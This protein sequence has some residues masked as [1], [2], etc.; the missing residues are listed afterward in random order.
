MS[1]NNHSESYLEL[2]GK[3][4]AF[5]RKYYKNL[6]IKG[7]LYSVGLILIFFLVVAVLEYVGN[8][9]PAVRGVMFYGLLLGSSVL[10]I[11]YIVIPALRLFRLGKVISHAEAAAIVGRHFGS[12]N[13]KVLNTLQLESLRSSSHSDLL[14]ASIDQKIAEL[15]PVPFTDAINFGENKKYLRFVIPP[16]LVLLVLLV[17]APNIITESTTRIVKHTESFE[18]VAPFSFHIEN[19]RLESPTQADYLLRLSMSGEQVP[20]RVYIVANGQRMKMK[21]DGT[22]LHSHKFNAVQEDIPFWFEASGFRSEDFV[23]RALPSPVLLHFDVTAS[24]PPH[25]RLPDETFKNTGNLTVPEGTALRWKFSTKDAD[26]LKLWINNEWFSPDR[27]AS[28]RFDYS[29]VAMHNQPYAVKVTNQFVKETD[30]LSYRLQVISDR[31]PSIDAEERADS[32]NTRLK[33]FNGLIKDDYGFTRLTFNYRFVTTNDSSRSREVVRTNLGIAGDQTQQQFFHYWNMG[34]LSLKAG[35]AVEYYFEVWDNDG[36]H[37]AKSSRSATRTYKAPSEDELLAERDQS[38]QKIKDDLEKAIKEARSL[39]K[40]AEDLNRELLEKK[41]LTWQDKKKLEDLVARQQQMQQ[42]IDQ[43]KQEN[44]RSNQRQE[45]FQQQNN[46][47]LEKQQQLEKLFEQVM[48][49]EMRKMYERLEELMNELDKDK[50]QQELEELKW[51]NK[52]VEKELDRALEQFKQLEFEMKM[53]ETLEKLEKLAEEQDK[54]AEESKDK[55]SDS[56]ELKEKQDKLNEEFEKLREDLD[57]LKEKNEE[58][59]TPMDMEDTD[60]MEE[61][62]GEDMKDSSDQLEQNQKSKASEKQEGASQKMKQMANQMA[63]MMSAQQEEQAAENMDDLRKL[64][65]NLIQLSFDQ[66]DIMEGLLGIDGRDPRY[67]ALSK[68]QKKAKDDAKMVEDSLFALS[69]RVPQLESIVNREISAINQNMEQAI[70]HLSERQTNPARSSQ[71]YV[72]TA[73]NNLALLLDEALQQMQQEMANKMPG[74][75]NCQ[76]PGGAGS[77]PSPSSLKQ[78]QDALGKKMAEMEKMLGKKDGKSQPGGTKGMSK[79]L[80][81]MAAEQAAIRKAIE[82]M[83]QEL[84]KDGSGAGNELN[85]LAKEMEEVEKDIVNKNIN[86]ETLR[87]QQDIMVRLLESERAEREREQ[88]EKRESREAK[89][90]SLSNPREFFEYNQRK[91]REIE[92]LKTVPPTLKPYYKNKVNEYFI[93]FDL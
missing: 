8:F 51:D 59:E 45:E 60:P 85:K 27:T 17:A 88:D 43:M 77:K 23:L 64:L 4:D 90:F 42:R 12:V 56:E 33:Y 18:P 70:D 65:D 93:K 41:E 61:E 91:E 92:L 31:Y 48:T 72:M 15:R 36:V 10:I 55:N 82:Q 67:T 19:E 89:D 7:V 63:A 34:E 13:D 73:I 74:T 52:D 35:E 84:N 22:L 24:Y 37:G 9:T 16:M 50:I 30:S 87:R 14:S 86:P 71:Q 46:Q 6:M 1:K 78:M 28:N 38:N 3:L 25:T 76:K 68:D 66:E 75:G 54:L 53:E 80:A 26:S 79:E 2:I 21:K 69:K 57:E 5:I 83:G 58:L 29:A 44:Q 11:Y 20:E 62:I 81:K 39:Q 47:I 32:N 40:E 49:E